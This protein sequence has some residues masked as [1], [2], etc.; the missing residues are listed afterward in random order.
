MLS[1]IM[2]L[3]YQP[4]IL[5]PAHQMLKVLSHQILNLISHWMWAHQPTR[6]WAYQPTHQIL[7]LLA[8]QILSLS[9]TRYSYQKD[10]EP[11]SL[12]DPEPISH[13]ILS[14]SATRYSVY[15]PDPEPTSPSDPELISHQI[16]SSSARL[17]C[18]LESHEQDLLLHPTLDTPT[19]GRVPR[20]PGGEVPLSCSLGT[21][22]VRWLC[23]GK[24]Y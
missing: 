24:V 10:P 14:L 20:K 2:S 7:S 15:Q 3:A 21:S 18:R 12:S 6:S 17:K 1:A 8:H 13:Q 9:A 19:K 11:T 22:W 16:L 4:A 5:K 23:I